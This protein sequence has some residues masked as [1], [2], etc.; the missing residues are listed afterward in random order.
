MW[1]SP[2]FLILQRHVAGCVTVMDQQELRKL[3]NRCIQECAPWCSATCPVHVDVKAMIAAMCAGDF[4]GAAS[5]F[6]K[7][8]PFPGIISLVCDHPC[9]DVCRRTAIDATV[10][11][12][13]LER[14]AWNHGSPNKISIEPLSGK[15]KKAA[16]VGAGLSGLTT[17]LELS[18]KGHKIVLFEAS[19]SLGGSVWDHPKTSLPRKVIQQD[20][21]IVRDSPIKIRLGTVLGRDFSLSDLVEDYDAVYL[22]VG[23]GFA[24]SDQIEKDESGRVKADPITFQ[25]GRPGVFAGGSLLSET[26]RRSPIRSISDGRRAAIS[27]DRFLQKVSLTASREN[28]GS[29]ET[30]LYTSTEGIAPLPE[31]AASDPSTGYSA[32]EAVEEAERCLRCE[33]M[34]CVK[35]CEFLAGFKGYPKKYIRQIYN[36][37]SIVM[38]QRHGNT[39]INSCSICG[40]CKEVCPEDLH[41]GEICKAARETMVKQGKMPPSAHEFALRDMAFSNSEK[42]ALKHHQAGRYFSTFLFFPGCQLTASSPGNVKKTYSYLMER[43]RGGVGLMLRCCGAPADWAGRAEEF[44][45]VISEFEGQWI[46]MGS[47]ELIVACS[48]CYSVFRTHLPHAK[49][50]SLWEVLDTLGLPESARMEPFAVAIHDPCTSRHEER[51][52]KS[53]RSILGTLG[54]AIHELPLNHDRTECCGFGGLMYF[55][56]R[57]LAEKVIEGRISESPHAYLAYCAMCRDHF[58]SK[59]KPTWHL[60]DLIFGPADRDNA[61]QR[62][63]DYSQRRENR[64]RLKNSLLKELW[65]EV[66]ATEHEATE[67]HI[68]NQVRELMER[69]MILMEDVRDV[70]DWAERTGFK[71][72]SRDSG[73]YLA[74]HTPTTV[75][76]WV[77]YSPA[78]K[79]F[80]I[81]NAYSHRMEIVE[82]LKP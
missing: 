61:S 46:E 43:L 7:K 51:I 34:E 19:F 65:G 10:S 40:L 54:Y 39:L 44:S 77:E 47:P 62:G 50:K 81:H 1:F 8:V 16:V 9:Q 57:D 58:S 14:A 59:G 55:A 31:V 37:L 17:A 82:E 33:C 71:L 63:P 18:K 4:A 70:I 12:R 24:W 25:T 15:G 30:R 42:C 76:Y 11:I 21:D 52:H 38:G 28:E 48:T 64:A 74:H 41:M 66:V 5:V 78:D 36:N 29:Y 26:G 35:V 80:T 68:S 60:L 79:G 49:I 69:R 20:F 6:Q 45:I 73:H 27:V 32:Q 72:V 67:L 2:N 53:V 23:A 22:G 13:S 75:T 3:E 56:N